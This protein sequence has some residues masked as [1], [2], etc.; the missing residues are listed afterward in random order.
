[1]E[2]ARRSIDQAMAVLPEWERRDP[3]FVATV[4]RELLNTAASEYEAAITDGENEVP[5]SAG[6]GN[7]DAVQTL[8]SVELNT[9]A[10][11]WPVVSS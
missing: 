3:A 11:C 7:D 6:A 5:A 4:I 8:P 9:C 2:E 1:M 10:V